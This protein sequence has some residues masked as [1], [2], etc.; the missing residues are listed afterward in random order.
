VVKAAVRLS[1]PSA[2]AKAARIAAGHS[3]FRDGDVLRALTHKRGAR[4]SI[5][6]WADVAAER[7]RWRVAFL[8][9]RGNEA[10]ASAE[11][12]SRV[13]GGEG[14]SRVPSLASILH[15]FAIREGRNAARRR[16]R[17]P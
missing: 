14:L 4:L 9:A 15:R 7:L 16:K 11:L 5:Q 13:A 10:P 2:V 1:D 6:P 3:V 12:L 17:K 8:D